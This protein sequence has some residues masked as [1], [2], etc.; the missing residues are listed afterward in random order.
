[1]LQGW[2]YGGYLTSMT[3]G[4][5]QPIVPYF[6]TAIAVAPVTDWRLYDSIYTER[7]MRTPALNDNVWGYNV[8]VSCLDSR[9]SAFLF[10]LLICWIL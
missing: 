3:I 7:Y 2:S 5:G 10:D 9:I 4:M 6:R 1:M 8:S